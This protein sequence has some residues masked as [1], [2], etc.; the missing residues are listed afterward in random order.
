MMLFYNLTINSSSFYLLPLWIFHM[1]YKHSYF[2]LPPGCIKPSKIVPWLVHLKNSTDARKFK[3]ST[4]FKFL[5]NKLT[6]PFHQNTLFFYKITF[7][8]LSCIFKIFTNMDHVF[9]WVIKRRT[10]LPCLFLYSPIKH[11][12]LDFQVMCVRDHT[13]TYLKYRTNIC[14]NT[15]TL[16]SFFINTLTIAAILILTYPACAYFTTDLFVFYKSDQ[17]HS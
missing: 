3:T 15:H 13:Y 16:L 1:L 5:Q 17:F 2:V 11:Y 14:K 6:I 10:L 9:W 8:D 12:K 4:M 7:M